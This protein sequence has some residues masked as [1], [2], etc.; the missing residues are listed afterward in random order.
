MEKLSPGRGAHYLAA[1][2]WIIPLICLPLS[3]LAAADWIELKDGTRVEGTIINV[4]P[5]EILMEVQTTPTIRAEKSFPRA[6]V[7]KFQ[8][9]SQD[10][11]A[12][13]EVAAVVVP[14][15]ADSPAVYEA[16]LEAK[17]RPFM[18]QFAYSKHMPEARKLAAQLEAEKARVEKGEVKIEGEWL[19]SGGAGSADLQ[20]RILLA[21]MKAAPDPASALIIFDTIE[22]KHATTSS[23]PTAVRLARQ[24]VEELRAA[25]LKTRTEAERRQRE[26]AEGLKLAS[27]DKKAIIQQGIDQDRAALKAQYDR[28]KQSGSKWLPLLP[29]SKALDE[30]TQTATTEGTRLA[31]LNIDPME[32]AVA[33]AGRADQALAAGDVAGAKTALAETEKL[34]PSYGR[35]TDLR[36]SVKAAETAAPPAP[37]S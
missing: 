3:G 36:A 16:I 10:D 11:L 32:Q 28:A 13:A 7:T 8:R 18:K 5:E 31:A 30:L 20:G 12:F 23:F 4:S 34:W 24:K 17:V 37:A 2:R 33:A 25:I 26:Q 14:A 1:V 21:R 29:D 15:T 9:A 35:I 27:E 6:D 22:K 19:A